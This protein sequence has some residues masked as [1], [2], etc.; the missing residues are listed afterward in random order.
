MAA[1][2]L[3]LGFL[4]AGIMGLGMIRNLLK[5]GHK[6]KVWNRS[7]EKVD[8]LVEEGASRGSTPAE[9]VKACDITIAMLADPEVAL[10]VALGEGGVIE[11]ISE[12]KS[13]VDMS[14]VDAGTSTKIG[15]AVAEKGGRFLEAPVSGSKK[16]A[17]EGTLIILAAGNEALFKT[18]APAFDAMGKK[19]FFLGDLGNGA[20]MKLVVNMI[21]G[22]MMASLSEGLALCGKAGISQQTLL[23]VLDL[24]VMSNGLF[25]LKG[26]SILQGNFPPAFPLKHQQKDMRLAL[27]VGDECNQPMPVAAAANEAYKRAKGMGFS[28][29]DFAAVFKAIQQ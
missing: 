23:E 13:Y 22:S 18:V 28:D 3:E 9:V 6:V 10:E 1:L 5:A 17:E 14:T 15:Q 11:G 19:S 26:S 2:E 29:E 8:A 25:K 21:M 16:P 4:G 27:A 20:R 12:G 24:G 7:P